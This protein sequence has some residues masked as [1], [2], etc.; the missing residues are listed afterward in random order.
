MNDHPNDPFDELMRRS[1][2][3]EADRIEPADGLH[4]IQARVRDQRKPAGRKPWMLT[5]G[6]AIVGTAAA[7]GAFT[8]LDDS[9]QAGND[10]EVA[11]PGSPSSSV[12]ASAS[13]DHQPT[14]AP[15]PS[16]AATRKPGTSPTEPKVEPTERGRL[17]PVTSRAVPV[18]W[19]GKAVGIEAGP[20]VR[21][22]RTWSRIKGR[23]AYE[24]LQLMTSGK[25]NDPDYTSPWTGAKVSSVTLTKDGITVD[26]KQLPRETL[27]PE[28]AHIA[29]QQ[30]VYTVQGATDVTAP[31]KVTERGQP[32][33]QLFGVAAR[34][35]MSRA[36]AQ[37]VQAYIWIDSPENNVVVD[38]P[39]KVTGIAAVNEAQLNWRVISEQ[40][41][42]VVDEGPA[43]TREAFKL[44]PYAFVVRPL[45]AGKYALEVFEISAADGRQTSTDSKTF[46]VK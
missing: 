28:D 26:F 41:Q 20:S 10:T 2:H 12:S 32:T 33:D 24:A 11:G 35:P 8:V 27:D 3:A 18:Y 17:E 15:T 45:P 46:V 13:T 1:L 36:Q 9:N 29:T 44:T 4:E 16:P 38:S 25:T 6:A 37:D 7:I 21:L 19:L 42:K 30:L 22:Y 40:T 34:Q 14:T 39:V 43:R 31:V 23:P 5:A